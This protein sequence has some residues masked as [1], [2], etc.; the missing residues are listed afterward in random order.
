MRRRPRYEPGRSQCSFVASPPCTDPSILAVYSQQFRPS[1]W[2]RGLHKSRTPS[3]SNPPR[4]VATGPQNLTL[5]LYHQPWW[6]MSAWPLST[7]TSTRHQQRP[8][9]APIAA[10]SLCLR[11]LATPDYF[12]LH[13]GR[14]PSRAASGLRSASPIGSILID[15]NGIPFFRS[16]ISVGI[17]LR[18]RLQGTA[19]S[20][21]VSWTARSN[22]TLPRCDRFPGN[23]SRI[24]INS[25]SKRLSDLVTQKP[26]VRGRQFAA[27]PYGHSFY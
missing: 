10:R 17:G 26:S 27:I 15:Y 19:K 5:I 23:F 3:E 20:I 6:A 12:P 25:R 24:N 4:W 8:V 21:T 11:V 14:L 2:S 18:G 22:L 16:A 1:S 9:V 7:L 13:P